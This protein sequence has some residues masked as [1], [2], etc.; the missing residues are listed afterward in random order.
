MTVRATLPANTKRRYDAY[1]GLTVEELLLLFLAAAYGKKVAMSL[2]E[3]TP[4][5]LRVAAGAAVLGLAAVVLLVR[6]PRDESGDK[7]HVWI[8]RALRFYR[9]RKRRVYR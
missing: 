5:A 1:W 3:G 6:W 8:S 9:F 2:P 7:I 4:G